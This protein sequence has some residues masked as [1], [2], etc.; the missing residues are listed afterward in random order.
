M[1]IQSRFLKPAWGVFLLS[2]L[3]FA[4]GH[5]SHWQTARALPQK[6]GVEPI[7][8]QV[9]TE[10]KT[11]LTFHYT[12]PDAKLIQTDSRAKPGGDERVMLGN[13][14]LSAA[15][16]EPRL[17]VIPC[18]FILPQ[19][20][21]LDAVEI[22]ACQ[23]APLSGKHSVEFAEAPTP[24]ISG[25]KVR[26]AQRKPS[27]YD[28]D[29]RYPARGYD[30]VSI[31][32]KRG[33]SIAIIALHPVTYY[34]KSG[35]L[36]YCK[37]L[38]VTVTTKPEQ[39]SSPDRNRLKLRKP[40]PR[41][42]KVEN[43]EAL[44]DYTATPPPGTQASGEGGSGVSP[45]GICNPAQSYRYVVITNAAI[46]DATTDV[47]I[48]DLVAQKQAKGISS[49]IVTV[50]DIY[51][52][53]SG[54]DNAEKVRNF[55]IDAYNNWET[56]FVLLGGDIAVV[57]MRKLYCSGGGETD[58]I[59][60]DLYFQCLDGT[61]NANGNAYWGEP[62]D[63]P[64]GTDVDLMAEI[65]IGRAS[66]ENAAEMSNFVYK[67]LA[68]ENELE[69]APYLHKAF[70]CGE[71]LGF[72]G[73]ADYATATM[74]QLRL[75]SSADGYSTVGFASC[76]TISVD[77]LYDSPSYTWSAST[78]LAKIN[79][80]AYGVIDH[81]G[82][83]NYDYDMK[84]Y[85]ADADALTNNKFLFAYSQGCIPGNF[86]VDCL[87]E[88]LTTSTRHG[89][90]AVVFNS[91]YGWG[92]FNSTDGPSQRFNR[93]FWDAY[94]NEKILSLGSINAD[95]HED[96]L[97]DISGDCIRWCYYETNLLGDPQTAMRG[98]TLG[99][100]LVYASH[101]VSDAAGNGDGVINPGEPVSLGV[102]VVNNGTN[103]TTGVTAVMTTTD[104]SCTITNG[105]A[106]FGD[107]GCCG[108]TA[109]GLTN[110]TI[111]ISPACPTPHTVTLALDVSDAAGT[112]WASQFA[113]TVYSSSQVSGYVRT[114]TGNNPIAGA[115]VSFSG[116]LSGSIVTDANGHY[117]FGGIDGA[118]TISA[119]APGYTAS[120]PRSV[121]IPPSVTDVNFSL[122]RPHLTLDPPAISVTTPVGG[123]VTTPL[124]IS[125][126]GDVPLTFTLSSSCSDVPS[127]STATEQADATRCTL[128]AES[129][130]SASH[131]LP[132]EK[133]AL[134][135][136]I[137]N[138]VTLSSGGPDAAGYRWIDSDAPS[139]PAYVWDDIVATG[140]MLTS[141]SGCDDCSQQQP[142]SFS[143]PFYGNNFS[144]IYVSSNGFVSLGTGSSSLSN[145]A[146]P[147]T[148][149]PTNLIAAF[150]DDLNPGS[151]GDVYF[152]DYGDRAIIQ[153]NNVY[154]YSGS[155][156]F[157]F[158][159]VLKSD[160]TVFYYYKS[161][162]GT[163]T[164]A[165]A[166]VQNQTG[167]IGLTVVYNTSYIKNNLAV[168]IASKQ[169]WLAVDTHSG[170]LAPGVSLPVTVTCSAAELLGGNYG[171]QLHIT[172]NDPTQASPIVVPCLMNAQGMR[173]LSVTPAQCD[174]GSV[175][176]GD[177]A[178]QL[179]TLSNSGNEA[180]TVSSVSSNDPVFYCQATT[181]IVVPA[182][183]STQVRLAYT[184]MAMGNQ[185]ATLGIA[186]N[187]GDNPSLEIGLTGRA[188]N[189]P[190]I[191]YSPGSFHETFGGGDSLSRVVTLKNSG[192]DSLRFAISLLGIA[193]TGFS[194]APE[195]LSALRTSQRSF[196]ITSTT[197]TARNYVTNPTIDSRS[198]TRSLAKQV[199]IVADGLPWGYDVIAP[200]LASMG[201][202]VTQ[203]PSSQIA[204][205]NLNSY[206]VIVVPSVQSSS[207][208]ANYRA[209]KA[210]FDSYVQAGGMLEFHCA[211]QGDT[212]SLPG[213][214]IVNYGA[215]PTNYVINRSHPITSGVDS[216]LNGSSASH[217]WFSNVPAN[218]ATLIKN[219]SN[220]PTLITYSLGLGTVIA[221]GMTWE[222]YYPSGLGN[223]L[224]PNSLDY[225]ITGAISGQWLS[226]NKTTG[227]VGPN[228][229]T[230]VAVKFSSFN[231]I[232]ST[233]AAMLLVQHNAPSQISPVA[234]SCTLTVNGVRRCA[235]SPTAFD[236]GK[237]WIGS[238]GTASLTLS[239]SGNQATTVSSITGTNPAFSTTA[240][241]PLTV[242]AFGNVTI[243]AT[244]HP[245]VT[246]STTG[247][248]TIANDAIDNPSLNVTLSGEG[249]VPP[250]LAVTPAAFREIV[251][252]GSSV[253][254]ALSISN[255]GQDTLRFQAS[256]A[257]SWLS[258]SVTSGSVAPGASFIVNL[259]F[260]SSGMLAGT[261]PGALSLTHND[262]SRGS[263]LAVPCTLDVSAVRRCVALPTSISFGTVH[264]GS[265][266]SQ[267]ITLSNTGNA[268]TT[269]TSISGPPGTVFL[270]T[271]VLPMTIGA[272]QNTTFQAIFTPVASGPAS[273]TFTFEGNAQDFPLPIPMSGT[274]VQPPRITLAP[275]IISER[276]TVG[277]AS[278]KTLTVYN[279]GEDL[280]HFSAAAI[281]MP[282]SA[283]APAASYVY[284][285]SNFIELE[286]GQ[287]D[288]RIGNPVFLG[289][290]GPD[291]FGY[292]WQDSD[293]SGGPAFVWNDI[294][295]T[296][297]VIPGVTGCGDCY[298]SVRLQFPFRF[299]GTSYDSL[300]IT[301]KGF[302][303]FTGGTYQ[304]SNYPLPSTSAPTAIICGFWDDL[305]TAANGQVYVQQ[306]TDQA[307]FQWNNIHVYG[308]SGNQYTFQIVLRRDGT[309]FMYYK[310]MTGPLTG[311]TV[312]IQNQT[313]STGLSIAY[314]T[315]YIKN[316]LAIRIS[317]GPTWFGL[318]TT[319][320]TI[321]PGSSLP[322]AVT[323]DAAALSSGTYSG[324]VR[325]THDDPSKTSPLD[326]P[327][328]LLVT[329]VGSLSC[330]PLRIGPSVTGSARGA[331]YRLNSL[332][333]GDAVSGKASGAQYVLRLAP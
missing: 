17:P 209:N 15:E 159:I 204:S 123:Q 104:P 315:S 195:V 11:T 8:V 232:A 241:F 331:L 158:Q 318:G 143:F 105:N 212:F 3:L 53:Y 57:P 311:A 288:T 225:A 127:V 180:T 112:H 162:S 200:L 317:N 223:P 95:S 169:D 272:F 129:I 281:D 306:T 137:G 330:T 257:M 275:Q 193:S 125:N 268:P 21:T 52:N 292:R 142:L 29:S 88:H 56:D 135:T 183:S 329:P 109:S 111:A 49:T 48:R 256:D 301:T 92:A 237:I 310:S 65:A 308:G 215:S 279:T 4:Q 280:L 51:A 321:A 274:G 305:S 27:I 190:G 304:Y 271:S 80:N 35:R 247:T 240:T 103:P 146:L 282:A 148:S 69:S 37:D 210:K 18:E 216:I 155:G 6:K 128:Q 295:A 266:G 235:V 32:K 138:P 229:S 14:P 299:Y 283:A 202:S 265:Q 309:I 261:Y 90:F 231:L 188:I 302:V 141:I 133:G 82:H 114:L 205:S 206:G 326:V 150:W 297:T 250:T 154:P 131:F 290:G 253:T 126:S 47:T 181:P 24:L 284:D 298:T 179:I 1:N 287:L 73:V 28:S 174:F 86:E 140:T 198:S 300:W 276:T 244:F 165:T 222:F 160:G 252:G 213:G 62:T 89:M 115:T 107:I 269:I 93:Q 291:A 178:S 122:G 260:N 219:A 152:K 322:I 294:S 248:L 238:Q 134:D 163:L 119:A 186:S 249:I 245:T 307:I 132:L 259:T 251:T 258:E 172:H 30:I 201:A 64:G 91:R 230:A 278:S 264:I 224:M 243:A 214:A 157:T 54:V 43:P 263:P 33:V 45:L 239:N 87:A 164:G 312:G 41:D 20:R 96:N 153:F 55:I 19:G 101:V 175:W 211:T 161:M 156:S 77:T 255:L 170:T 233:Y 145:V 147:S 71:Y 81:L 171:G 5:V 262:P 72:G 2:G 270:H 42:L 124:I 293:Q 84:F 194:V 242:P 22:T 58:E 59:P 289:S 185:T 60:S 136:R 79:S 110:Y 7:M 34:P 319:S 246:G 99:P 333:V 226:V 196:S 118:Y 316:N 98:Q 102:T 139:G 76:P 187:A 234:I 9:V 16:G 277:T 66:A 189:G 121:A 182:F 286:H 67:T 83:A 74:E 13:A 217:T 314:N 328:S 323:L 97:W 106:S 285:K 70:T 144:G 120:A 192:D 236:F 23:K 303:S 61:Y 325:F 10:G 228:D 208:Y 227:V 199:L 313:A 108:A 39:S 85:N 75:G 166:G 173:R 63:G 267:S 46:R 31:Q 332:S 25:A 207:F 296:G 221:T 44:D 12:S 36:E 273:G 38:K 40:D 168:R 177:S 203:I 327:V 130:Y 116:P 254:R 100:S 218:A 324:I 26:K 78:I 320:G 191:Q 149:A 151:G 176:I 68:Y 117:L 113:V 197:D 220:Q 167:A 50:E 94:F 184:P